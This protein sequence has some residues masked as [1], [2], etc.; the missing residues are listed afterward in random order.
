MIL[1]AAGLFSVLA[2]AS[3][4]LG[5]LVVMI[6][7]TSSSSFL[8]Q[9]Q[10]SYALLAQQIKEELEFKAF[11]LLTVYPPTNHVLAGFFHG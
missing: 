11:A 3:I 10:Q 5:F 9:V 7:R 4:F 8:Q 2:D 1:M 6:L